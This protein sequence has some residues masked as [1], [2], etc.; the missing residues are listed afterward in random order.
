MRIKSI[1][2]LT[3]CLIALSSCGISKD[4]EDTLSDVEI[5]DTNA[6]EQEVNIEV[7]ETNVEAQEINAEENIQE[8]EEEDIVVAM[9]E[10]DE[11][12][13]AF[14][15]SEIPAIWDDGESVTI[16]DELIPMRRRRGARLRKSS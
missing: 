7:N 9:S 5:H 6:E 1:V 16:Y 14:L 15:A 10:P 13:D 11:L 3:L 12:L 4:Y 2:A 8:P